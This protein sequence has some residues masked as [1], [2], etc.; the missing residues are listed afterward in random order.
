MTDDSVVLAYIVCKDVA[1]AKAIG[2][3]LLEQRLVA[4]VNIFPIQSAHWW[5]G[6]IVEDEEA[7][8]IAKTVNRNFETVQRAVLARHSYTVPC[9]IKLS[10]ASAEDKYLAWLRG[11]VR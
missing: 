8:L 5:E 10:V 3:H 7:V 9:V 6:Q 11:E 2:R 1:E 4:C